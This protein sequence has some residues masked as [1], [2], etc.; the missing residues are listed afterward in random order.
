MAKGKEEIKAGVSP[1]QVQE[2]NLTGLWSRLR[3]ADLRFDGRPG[4]GAG[5]DVGIVRQV[6]AE[7]FAA[8]GQGVA[9]N[10]PNAETLA[11]GVYWDM[12]DKEKG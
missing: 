9:V 10:A 8:E 2:K 6:A 1:G 11:F 3:A 5:S 7:W 4:Y 12:H